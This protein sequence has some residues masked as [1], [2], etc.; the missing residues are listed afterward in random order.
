M[1]STIR[2]AAKAQPKEN[3]DSLQRVNN[4]EVAAKE[5]TRVAVAEAY[6]N[7]PKVQVTGSPMYRE[8]FGTQMPLSINGII[9]YLPL[10]G[11]T[12]EI[13]QSFAELFRSRIRSVDDD[14]NM[15]KRL[16]DVTNNSESYAG[17]LDLVRLV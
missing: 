13:P 14:L 17:E 4:A 9:L 10:D 6:K 3:L 16:G 1:A 2:P 7:E 5:R 12:Y 11:R 15:R 8:Y